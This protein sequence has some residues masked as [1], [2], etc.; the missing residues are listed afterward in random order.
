MVNKQQKETILK[1]LQNPEDK[2]DFSKIYDKVF[3]CI[4]NRV[5]VFSSFL[6]PVKAEVFCNIFEKYFGDE[7]KAVFFG[8]YEDCERGIIGLFPVEYAEDEEELFSQFQIDCIKISHNA[9]FVKTPSHRD[10]LGSIIG[11]G[12]TRDVIG[13]IL[14]KE[15]YAVMFCDSSISSYIEMNLEKVGRASVKLSMIYGEELEKLLPQ[16]EV[17][18]YRIIVASLRLDVVISACFK[19]PRSKAKEYID[20]E[21]AF[22]NWKV[23]SNTSKIVEMGNII[24]LRKKGRCKVVEIVGNTKKDRIVLL[25]E[26]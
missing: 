1:Q 15:E 25:V 9:K 10:Y 26:M 17:K 8:G 20:K 6:N 4:K 13:D 19:L 14:I 11:L 21:K 16:K 7:I 18:E 3:I 24:T 22:I 23:V 5:T 12:I 2:L